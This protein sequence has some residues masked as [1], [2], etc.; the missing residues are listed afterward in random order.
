[1]DRS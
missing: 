1:M